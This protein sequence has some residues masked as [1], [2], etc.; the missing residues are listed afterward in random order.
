V[1]PGCSGTKRGTNFGRRRMVIAVIFDHH[2]PPAMGSSLLLS[3][4]PGGS[5][6]LKDFQPGSVSP[7][8][9][10]H[11]L[12][13]IDNEFS[14]IKKSPKRMSRDLILPGVGLCAQDR[15]T[16]VSRRGH[17]CEQ[18]IGLTLAPDIAS[19]HIHATAPRPS[20]VCL[21]RNIS[22][23]WTLHLYLHKVLRDRLYFLN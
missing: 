10:P 11:D 5:Y 20:S 15:Q 6:T 17:D 16:I 9:D 22:D 23:K 14:E 13:S 4:S 18:P 3:R 12:I 7:E 1:Q 2:P 21:G 19:C 8:A